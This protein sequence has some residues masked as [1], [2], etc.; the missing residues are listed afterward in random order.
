MR[1]LADRDAKWAVSDSAGIAFTRMI[2]NA[3]KRS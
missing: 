2:Y 3:F 1:P